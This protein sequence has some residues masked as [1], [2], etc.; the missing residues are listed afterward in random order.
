MDHTS[1]KSSISKIDK[2]QNT[3]QGQIVKFGSL[4]VFSY[5]SGCQNGAV[6]QSTGI[7]LIE[8]KL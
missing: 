1:D 3:N 7:C 6:I 4:A 5:T 8:A 2:E